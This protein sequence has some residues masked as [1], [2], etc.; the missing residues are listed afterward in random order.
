M[1]DETTATTVEAFKRALQ[2]DK[3]FL[4]SDTHFG[5]Q[6][7]ITYC[8]RPFDSVDHM[9]SEIVETFNSILDDDSVLIHLGDLLM[10]DRE[11]GLAV[12][13]EIRGRKFI[14]PGNHDDISSLMTNA[15]RER[16]MPLFEE[17]GFEILPE[18]VREEV[19]GL[20]IVFNHYP[21]NEEHT[22]SNPDMKD[23]FKKY[24]P[25]PS[26]REMVVHGHTHQHHNNTEF[27]HVGVDSRDFMPVPLE[28]VLEEAEMK[29]STRGKQ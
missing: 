16:F 4:T 25:R 5:H 17:A 24:R 11:A 23:K 10:G 20:C 8:D 3:V 29:I 1:T 14:I 13:S 22:N 9:N 21:P 26:D 2:R 28:K 27:V 15:R 6:N 12:A 19:G 18:E 7:I